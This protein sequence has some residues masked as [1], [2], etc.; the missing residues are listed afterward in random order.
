MPRNDEEAVRLYRRA[1]ELDPGML[2]SSRYLNW[3]WNEQEI[4]V[5]IPWFRKYAE[6]GEAWAR[7]IAEGLEKKV[8]EAGV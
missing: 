1:F 6:L 7:E 5:S 3:K 2:E 4:A 8:A